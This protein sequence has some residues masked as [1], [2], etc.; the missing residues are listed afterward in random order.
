MKLL[1]SRV[2][3]RAAVV[4]AVTISLVLGMYSFIT[5]TVKGS[6]AT[7]AHAA[8]SEKNAGACSHASVAVSE[9][10]ATPD[11]VFAGC[12]GFLE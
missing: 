9:K 4:V 11:H 12:A 8:S 5:A 10:S 7:L 1:A 6:P 2:T 3:M